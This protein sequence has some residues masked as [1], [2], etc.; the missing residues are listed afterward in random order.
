MPDPAGVGWGG[1]GWGG[2]I[3]DLDRAPA[4]LDQCGCP[5]EET[6][7]R[8]NRFH[9][10]LTPSCSSTPIPTTLLELRHPGA[11]RRYPGNKP[12]SLAAERAVSRSLVGVRSLEMASSAWGLGLH[13]LLPYPA[14]QPFKGVTLTSRPVP[15]TLQLEAP[16]EGA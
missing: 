13:P 8:M 4:L 14:A 15:L 2:G 1:L 12:L 7:T 6:M 10:P 16:G 5:V 11:C 3:P 9:A